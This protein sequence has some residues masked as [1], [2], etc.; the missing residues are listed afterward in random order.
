MRKGRSLSFG[1]AS[2]VDEKM[3]QGQRKILLCPLCD[4]SFASPGGL[5]LHK[6]SVHLK[7]QF[8]CDIC[9]KVYINKQSMTN[10]RKNAHPD[11][12]SLSKT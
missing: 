8:S 11:A 4:A 7:R 2:R 10:H 6:S 12:P 3:L 1:N 9:Q 5:S